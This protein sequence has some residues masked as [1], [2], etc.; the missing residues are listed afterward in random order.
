[1]VLDSISHT[2]CRTNNKKVLITDWNII[3][4]N[5]RRFYTIN[6]RQEG[7]TGHFIGEIKY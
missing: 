4:T 3:Q 5:K 2:Y 6:E 1:M 7:R